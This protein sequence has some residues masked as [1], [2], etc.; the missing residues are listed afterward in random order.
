VVVLA[1]VTIADACVVG[2]GSVVTRSLEPGSI[3]VG[4]PARVVRRRSSASDSASDS[5]SGTVAA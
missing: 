4:C 5:A 2:A 3:A 1:G